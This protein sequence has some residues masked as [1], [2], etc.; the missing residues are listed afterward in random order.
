MARKAQTFDTQVVER[1]GSP[2][3]RV[4]AVVFTG[5]FLASLVPVT[6]VVSATHFPS[7]LRSPAEMVAYYL[8]LQLSPS[9]QV[10]DRRD[11]SR[12]LAAFPS[13]ET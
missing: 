4:V 10:R 3:P 1:H 6:L 9:D 12:D 2:N 13:E 7:P 11:R 5:L 8:S